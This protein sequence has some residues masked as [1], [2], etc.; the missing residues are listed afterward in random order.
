MR[1][2]IYCI[3]YAPE[4]TGIGKYT[5]EMAEW[6]AAQGHEVRVIAAPPY[7]PEWQIGPGYS[8]TRYCKETVRGVSVWRCPLWVPKKQSGKNRLLHLASFALTSFPAMLAQ[9]FWRPDVVLVIEPPF[10]CAPTAW[11]IARLNGA[12]AWLHIQDFE[13]DAAFELGF[14][15]SK[16]L[17]NF[18]STI[19]RWM[20]RRFD[21]VST[22]SRNMVGRLGAKGVDSARQVFFPNWVDAETIFPLSY[23]SSFRSEL[24]IPGDTIVALY[25]GNMGEKQGLDILLE[26][27]QYLADRQD[28][29]FV[30]C[31]EGTAKSRLMDLGKKLGNVV[32]LSLQPAERL[33]DLLNLADIHL[34][35]QR[36]DA[37]DLVMP[38]KLLGM[39]ASARPVIA[40][41]TQGTELA[42]MAEGRGIVVPPGEVKGLVEAIV[43][44]AEDG[45]RRNR[46][47]V[48]ARE[49]VVTHYGKAHVLARLEYQLK[50]LGGPKD[51]DCRGT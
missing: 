47:G 27:A 20:M 36:A 44:L 8:A 48:S 15:K 30:L 49:Y 18:V 38:S 13:I 4:L 35:P 41:S 42:S 22:I 23:P 17:R 3:N 34:L 14:L 19:E 50:R 43:T 33:N 46:M 2:L 37:A 1:L 29:L 16:T 6:L 12:K 21:V 11:G 51:E 28:L 31:G 25:A 45:E 40:T 24:G 26:A 39:Y 7:Y 9:A 5:G 32:F 10:F